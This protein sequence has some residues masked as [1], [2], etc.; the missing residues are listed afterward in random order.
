MQSLRPLIDPIVYKTDIM[1]SWGIGET[2]IETDNI[3]EEYLLLED[4]DEILNILTDCERG[5]HFSETGLKPCEPCE[6]CNEHRCKYCPC[7]CDM[8]LE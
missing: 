7:E 4:F 2:R 6:I 3:L 5:T 8:Y 1:G